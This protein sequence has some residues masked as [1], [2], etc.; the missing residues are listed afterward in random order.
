M[1]TSSPLNADPISTCTFAPRQALARVLVL[2]LIALSATVLPA[3][4]S[5]A[6]PAFAAK[7]RGATV[8]LTKTVVQGTTITIA[9]R[10]RLPVDSAKARKRTVVWLSLTS[11]SQG[12]KHSETFTAKLD[13]KGRF[14]ATHATNLVGALGLRVLVRIDGKISGKKTL[15]TV[16][17]ASSS[18]SDSTGASTSAGTS[19]AGSSTS[20]SSPS[21]SSTSGSSPSERSSSGTETPTG[22]VDLSGTFELEPGADDA[23][24][25]SG[26]WFEM[27]DPE[28][29]P[30]PLENGNSPLANKDYTPLLPGTD[31]GLETFAYEPAP[32]PAF[33]SGGNALAEEIMQPQNFFGDNF[34]VVS[35]A[36][37]PQTGESDPLPQIV[38]TNGQLSGQITAWSVGWNKQWFNQGSPKPNGTT[39]GG[40]TT[41]TGTYDATTGHYVL[42]WKSLIVGGPFNSYEGSWHLEGT[43]V[44]AG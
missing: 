23:G 20:G 2:T 36:S 15:D 16:N 43:F 14:L 21:G 8:T 19:P 12:A 25:I 5:A 10:V 42:E 9:G 30:R 22:P 13:A 27:L 24:A 44:P 35:Q 38:D 28:S 17:V 4:A 1:P 39:P 31:K 26:S 6:G 29:P 7:A 37:D 33:S 11:V 41:P 40:T 3:A 34:S 18:K 32:S